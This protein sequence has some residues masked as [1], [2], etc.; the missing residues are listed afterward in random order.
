[1]GKSTKIESRLAVES[2]C[3]GKRE[4]WGA[5]ANEPRVFLGSNENVLKHNSSYIKNHWI[6]YKRMNF[7]V[8]E[9]N[10]GI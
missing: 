6:I 5:T 4:E 8:Y 9:F 1:M 2:E 3:R 7:M 10:Y